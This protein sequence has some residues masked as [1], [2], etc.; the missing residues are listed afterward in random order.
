[1]NK[2]KVNIGIVW[3][4]PYNKNMGVAALAYSSLAL[5]SDVLQENNIPN[6]I[7]FFGSSKNTRD[8]LVINGKEIEF[9][10]TYGL[11]FLKIKSLIKL[12]VLYKKLKTKDVFNFDYVFDI[13]E[14]DS[15]TDIY[16]SDRFKR[17]LNSKRVFS[18]FGKKQMLLPQ[19]IGPFKNK[20]HEKSVFKILKKM[21]AVISRDKQSYDYTAKHLPSQQI[22]ESID[23]A[24][25]LPY[26][27]SQFEIDKIHVGINIS[28]LLWNGGYTNN[29]QFN[30]KANYKKLIRETITY[31]ENKKDIVVH[32][33]P[34]VVPTDFPT[35]DDYT[36]AQ[37]IKTEFPKVIVA[38]RFE[39][40]IEA[41]SYISGLDFFTGARMHACIAA[42]SSG[43]PVYPMAYS[44]KFNGLFIETLRYPYLGDCVNEKEDE[45]LANM[46]NAFNQRQV[47]ADQINN[48]N[49]TIVTP[50]LNQ[51][52]SIIKDFV[53]Q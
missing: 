1:M 24:F 29:N 51:L 22:M 32:I 52:K 8:R 30:L 11:D 16:G 2:E 9:D 10:N 34:H 48:A 15:F 44:R 7:T 21:N 49:K 3:A 38:P 4:N 35:E 36:I 41:K 26:S 37:Q 42:F 13:A 20:C 47:L 23:V 6:E 27:K 33:V 18:Y 5:I 12:I 46:I 19:T 39:S 43:I 17:I 45:I 50:R 53:I 28:G 25:Y 31:F 14:G 40:P